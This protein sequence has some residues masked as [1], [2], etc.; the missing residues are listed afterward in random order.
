MEN[1][2][3]FFNIFSAPVMSKLHKYVGIYFED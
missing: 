3:I 1:N 2:C